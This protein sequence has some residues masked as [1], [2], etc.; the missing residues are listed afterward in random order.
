MFSSIDNEILR[1]IVSNIIAAI[2]TIAQ[3][4]AKKYDEFSSLTSELRNSS[5]GKV[6]QLTYTQ[7][8]RISQ[9]DTAI[10]N[11]LVNLRKKAMYEKDCHYLGYFMKLL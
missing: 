8:S 10:Y 1:E 7:E 3:W 2:Y 5:D 9:L 4:Y 6:H 11:L